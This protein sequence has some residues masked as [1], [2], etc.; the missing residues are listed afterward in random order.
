[1]RYLIFLKDIAFLINTNFTAMQGR[2]HRKTCIENQFC[3]L[4]LIIFWPFPVEWVGAKKPWSDIKGLCVHCQNNTFNNVSNLVEKENCSNM[5]QFKTTQSQFK[6][7]HVDNL[8]Y[9]IWQAWSS[10]PKLFWFWL[11]L[12]VNSSNSKKIER[13]CQNKI[14]SRF[15]V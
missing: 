14:C 9:E 4:E 3:Q 15:V 12:V 13:Q 1:M 2:Y 11:N 8:K 10:H 6:T 5:M 7:F